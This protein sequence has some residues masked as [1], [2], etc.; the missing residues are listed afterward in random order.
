[1]QII[2]EMV[3]LACLAVECEHLF[4]VRVNHIIEDGADVALQDGERGKEFM[5]DIG[6]QLLAVCFG[7]FQ[8]PGHPVKRLR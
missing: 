7:C 8:Y 6:K 3:E 5:A 1:M 2:D 4:F